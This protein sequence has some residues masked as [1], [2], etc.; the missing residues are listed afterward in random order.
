MIVTPKRLNRYIKRELDLKLF[1][2]LKKSFPEENKRK[3]VRVKRDLID[4][5]AKHYI[6]ML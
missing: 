3:L 4:T 5:M 6:W 2:V 1:D